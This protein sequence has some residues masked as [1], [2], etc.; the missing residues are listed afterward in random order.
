M[1]EAARAKLEAAGD[2][3]S[4]RLSG[5]LDFANVPELT[6]SLPAMFTNKRQITVDLSGVTRTNSAGMALLLEMQR[7]ARD[8][9]C[10]LSLQHLPPSLRNIIRISELD[11]VLPVTDQ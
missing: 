11:S 5:V 10:H 9:E 8:S 3:D 6:Q 7:L 4:Y 1:S 2:G